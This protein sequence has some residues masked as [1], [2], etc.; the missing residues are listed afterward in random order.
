MYML[1]SF[2]LANTLIYSNSAPL[3]FPFLFPFTLP[4]P[5]PCLEIFSHWKFLKE[6]PYTLV[7]P[8][9]ILIH[10]TEILQELWCSWVFFFFSCIPFSTVNISSSELPSNEQTTNH[11]M[12]TAWLLCT[13]H[14]CHLLSP[15]NVGASLWNGLPILSYGWGNWGLGRLIYWILYV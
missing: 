3:F 12:F 2:G 8:Q 1:T 14:M 4:L 9:R 6:F 15:Q 5:Q 11:L 10:P 13:K 7:S